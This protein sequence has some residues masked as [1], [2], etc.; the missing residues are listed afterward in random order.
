MAAALTT[1]GQ[2]AGLFGPYLTI[3]EGSAT[4]TYAAVRVHE[5]ASGDS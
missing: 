1:D 3:P 5:G 4:E 2:Y